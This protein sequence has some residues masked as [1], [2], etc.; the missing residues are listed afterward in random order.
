MWRTYS[1]LA[2]STS[3][4]CKYR[5]F[6]SGLTHTDVRKRT[7][8]HWCM[9]ICLQSETENTRADV[10]STRGYKW[11][12]V[13]LYN[14]HVPPS[15]PLYKYIHKHVCA[16]RVPFGPGRLP[17]CFLYSREVKM[18]QRWKF[19]WSLIKS[20]SRWIFIYSSTQLQREGTLKNKQRNR[21]CWC[22]I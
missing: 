16:V 3:M 8:V 17:S 12:S 18:V 9:C 19:S 1:L 2:T 21:F 22:K 5:K 4:K 11:C 14:G 20:Y 10:E 6:L 15:L 13:T 7:A